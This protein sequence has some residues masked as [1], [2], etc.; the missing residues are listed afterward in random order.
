MDLSKTLRF[1]N[2]LIGIAVLWITFHHSG[3]L[4]ITPAAD[5]FK[6][7]GY[8]GVDFCV[9]A[10]GIGCY[11]S[12]EKDPDILRFLKRRIQRLGPTYLCFIIPWLLWKQT[13]V[14]LPAH[15]ILGNILGLEAYVSWQYIFN[16]YIGGL[17]LFYICLPYFK[18]IT[19]SCSSFRQDLLVCLGLVLLGIPFCGIHNSL[20][21]LT[22]LPVLYAGVVYA[23]LAKQG[24]TLKVRDTIAL[25]AAALLGSTALITMQSKA[26][27]LLLFWGLKWSLYV[28]IVPGVSVLIAFLAAKLETIKYLRIINRFLGTAGIYS[29]ELYLVHC[30]L[31]E[32]LMPLLPQ[33]PSVLYS[34]ILWVATIP[35]LFFCT[36]ALNRIP[37]AIGRMIR[38]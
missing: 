34:N 32:D 36:Y 23:K 3:F 28:L 30:F 17:L 8:G 26:P 20:I 2:H 9:F 18:R 10:S 12:L 7:F 24:Y 21:I 6:S 1:R 11:F 5:A 37:S 27:D 14:A 4:V 19:D 13:V 29:F 33:I 15:S 16:W 38:R 35:A 25:A 31:Y 22:R